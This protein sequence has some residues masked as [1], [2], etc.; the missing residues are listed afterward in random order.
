MRASLDD[1]TQVVSD[2]LDE[3]DGLEMSDAN[4]GLALVVAGLSRI[5]CEPDA[6]AALEAYQEI[7]KLVVA[8]LDERQREVGLKIN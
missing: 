3:L 7:L 1:L 5:S 8:G 2:V 6:P 4:S